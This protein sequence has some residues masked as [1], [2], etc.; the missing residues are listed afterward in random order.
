MLGVRLIVEGNGEVRKP[1]SRFARN[2]TGSEV[3][4]SSRQP[5]I[6]PLAGRGVS[7]KVTLVSC[8]RRLYSRWRV[9][10]IPHDEPGSRNPA[11]YSIPIFTTIMVGFRCGLSKRTTDMATD[12]A[13]GG[14]VKRS[15]FEAV[16][17]AEP[18][19]PRHLA[20]RTG[21]RPTTSPTTPRTSQV[22]RQ[23]PAGGPRRPQEPGEGRGRQALHVHG[24]AEDAR[25][26]DDRGAYLA[27]DETSPAA[28]QRHA[29]ASPP[30]RACSSTGSCSKAT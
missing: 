6:G 16:K 19:A 24:P 25:R 10:S 18:A 13:A 20:G 15:G 14:E 11:S 30:A 2:G 27:L 5:R 3:L 22:P 17:E 21:F 8:N 9:S 12:E 26:E 4:R 23:L 7:G 29:T 28:R 1:R